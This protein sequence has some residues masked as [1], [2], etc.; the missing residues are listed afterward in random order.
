MLPGHYSWQVVWSLLYVYVYWCNLGMVSV[1]R[2]AR[3]TA[4]MR[5]TTVT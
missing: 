4:L 3:H 5:G 1:F 2:M